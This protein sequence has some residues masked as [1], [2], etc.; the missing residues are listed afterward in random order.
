MEI[1]GNT[2]EIHN[3]SHLFYQTLCNLKDD[4]IIDSSVIQKWSYDV[5]VRFAQ[6]DCSDVLNVEKSGNVRIN[7]QTDTAVTKN[8]FVIGITTCLIGIKD[9]KLHI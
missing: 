8:D 4:K 7:F 6:S 2:L 1:N 5:V 9:L 3:I